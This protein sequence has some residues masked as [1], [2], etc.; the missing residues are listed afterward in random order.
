VQSQ[1][2]RQWRD[3]DLDAG[4]REDRGRN[5]GDVVVLTP[6]FTFAW[7]AIRPVDDERVLLTTAVH[8]LLEVPKRRVAGHRPAR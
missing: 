4:G 7:D 1:H 8:G 3:C 2:S 5:I 6:N